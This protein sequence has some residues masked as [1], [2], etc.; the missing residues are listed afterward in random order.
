MSAQRTDSSVEL[1]I[2]VAAKSST[3]SLAAS[4]P[5]E[6]FK[7]ILAYVGSAGRPGYVSDGVRTYFDVDVRREEMKQL[8]A[9]ALTCVYWAQSTRERMFQFLILR[10]SKDM[11]G[12][13]S[14]LRAAQSPRIPP[15]CD[16]LQYL[17]VY[18][19][20]GDHPW[21]HNLT[22]LW[23][24]YRVSH[25]DQIELHITGP[26]R[27]AFVTASSRGSMLH[28]LFFAAP[29]TLPVVW[30]KS[31]NFSLHIE[32][33]H[34]PNPT[35][36]SNLLQDCL[37]LRLDHVKCTNL[38]WDF[39]PVLQARA[40]PS[41]IGLEYACRTADKYLNVLV[42]GCTDDTLVAAMLKSVRHHEF[43][44][45]RQSPRLDPL[46]SSYLFDV[47]HTTWYGTSPESEQ[48]GTFHI[49]SDSDSES[50]Q[51]DISVRLPLGILIWY[52]CKQPLYHA[53]TSNKTI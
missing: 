8:S 28:P 36:L 29:R 17:A 40:T 39:D 44:Q 49:Q 21:F 11:S 24:R 41:S 20:L 7:N 16:I 9:C 50:I 47:M 42:S 38:T 43:S 15:I 3:S 14:L 48:T 18:Y 37:S 52:S 51:E 27:P 34:L 22:G 4:I 45:R 25:L 33:I 31:C 10:S 19:T 53:D 12:Y 13:L 2:A 30:P 46:E 6:L 32:N 23:A 35:V 5:P 26:A 1:D